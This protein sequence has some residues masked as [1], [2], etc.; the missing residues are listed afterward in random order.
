MQAT[1]I[2][3][4]FK[5]MKQ[6]I[7]SLGHSLPLGNPPTEGVDLFKHNNALQHINPPPNPTKE[8]M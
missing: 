2:T 5:P 4:Q 8:D 6:M 1:L 3:T 7:I